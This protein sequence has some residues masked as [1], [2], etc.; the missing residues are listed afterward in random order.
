MIPSCASI[1]RREANP[2]LQP[3]VLVGRPQDKFDAN[4]RLTDDQTRHFLKTLLDRVVER[5]GPSR[6]RGRS[7]SSRWTAT[8]GDGFSNRRMFQNHQQTS[9]IPH[10]QLKTL[11]TLVKMVRNPARADGAC[12]CQVGVL[13]KYGRLKEQLG[14][15]CVGATSR[16]TEAHPSRLLGTPLR[17]DV[18]LSAQCTPIVP[19]SLGLI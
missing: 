2:L 5:L 7:A 13:A 14:K 3:E 19:A 12:C 4:G 11:G 18:G 10:V 17:L 8:G 6:C 16:G 9:P 1:G 15:R